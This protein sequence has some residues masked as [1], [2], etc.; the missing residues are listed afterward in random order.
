MEGCSRSSGRNFR[1]LLK[2]SAAATRRGPT[3]TPAPLGRRP[4]EGAHFPRRRAVGWAPQA[5]SCI[6]DTM[7]PSRSA[8]TATYLLLGSWVVL[9]SFPRPGDLVAMGCTHNHFHQVLI[10]SRGVARKTMASSPLVGGPAPTHTTD[11]RQ[12]LRAGEG[13]GSG[14]EAA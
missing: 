7:T 2:S 5:P 8:I 10:P 13:D 12:K 14:E 9:T 6:A 4:L 3:P 1:L 11:N